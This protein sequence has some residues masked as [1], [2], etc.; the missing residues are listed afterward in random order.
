MMGIKRQSP[1]IVVTTLVCLLG[2]SLGLAQIRWLPNGER[3]ALAER[4]SPYRQ[5]LAQE[6]VPIYEG[7]AIEDLQAL[8]LKLNKRLGVP[9]A[10]V[11]LEGTGNLVDAIVM[12]IPVGQ[13]SNAERHIFEE[14]MMILSGEGETVIWQS[15][16]KK[17]TV[18]WRKGSI[19]SPPLN[20]WHQHVNTGQQPVKFVTITFAPMVVDIYRDLDFVYNCPYDFTKRY[21]GQDNYFD[22]EISQDYPPAN[23]HSLS[24]VNFVR[25][26]FAIRL[27]ASGQGVDDVC[28]HF[29][30][31]DNMMG[32]HIEEFPVGTYERAHW[33]GPG[34]S[35]LFME[36]SGYT[37][38][39]PREFGKTPFADGK[40]DEITRIDWKWGSLIVP[41]QGWYHQHF[42]T[43]D[44]GARW[45]KLG[46]P[47]GNRIYH[48][49]TGLWTST[50]GA[51]IRFSEED[52]RVREIFAEDLKK[53][54]GT[55][56][57]PPMKELIVL[58]AEA[59]KYYDRS[60]V[61]STQWPPMRLPT[62]EHE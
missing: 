37:L 47:P 2:F 6:G 22:P 51:L 16:E 45:V 18:R 3:E 12:E 32:I 57:M 38:M 54:G 5:W 15:D 27:F 42:N 29:V 40:E 10:Y 41:P 19:F 46:T 61:P 35:L 21:N 62:H 56:K 7:F 52:S 59:E 36:G 25:N 13:S 31:S 20:A 55:M 24:I 11:L 53:H 23:D 49:T 9:A 58:E 26:A 48:T 50:S 34:T 33:H 43:G 30:M 17:H 60:K 39:W 14:Q 1:V 28:R 8:E 4:P 44:R